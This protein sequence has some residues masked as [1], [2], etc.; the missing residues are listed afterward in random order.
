MHSY[1]YSDSQLEGLDRTRTHTVIVNFEGLDRT[2]THTVIVHFEGLDRTRTHTV[3][4]N[5]RGLIA[6]VH[7]PQLL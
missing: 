7:I 3:I 5:L 6:L 4:V 1:T 2:R